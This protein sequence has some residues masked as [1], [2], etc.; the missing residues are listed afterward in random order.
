MNKMEL[1]KS[2]CSVK[3]LEGYGPKPQIVETSNY[4]LLIGMPT[5]W[6]LYCN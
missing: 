2:V 1:V 5:P 3:Y 6:N 4:I